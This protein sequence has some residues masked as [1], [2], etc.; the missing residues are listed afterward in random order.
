MEKENQVEVLQLRRLLYDLHSLR[1]DIGVRFRVMGEMWQ[2][3]YLHVFKVTEHGVALQDPDSRRL[4]LIPDLAQ[5]MQ[6]ELE[7]TFRQ[8]DAL[9]HY[10]VS[11]EKVSH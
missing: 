9:L 10:D 2:P 3:K 6:F 5:V 11:P 4:L 7:N 1:P 8:Y